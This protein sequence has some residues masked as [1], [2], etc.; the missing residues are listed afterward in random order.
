LLTQLC[1]PD[2]TDHTATASGF[3]ASAVDLGLLQDLL[4]DAIKLFDMH[5]VTERWE[6]DLGAW[7]RTTVVAWVQRCKYVSFGLKEHG[8]HIAMQTQ[9]DCGYYE[10]EFDVFPGRKR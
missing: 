6:Q 4:E 7:F 3:P 5:E 2:Q 9:D 8:V 10:Y 1:R